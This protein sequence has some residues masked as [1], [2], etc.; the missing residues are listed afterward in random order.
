MKGV[1][2]V[3]GH[4]SMPEETLLIEPLEIKVQ[5]VEVLPTVGMVRVKRDLVNREPLTKGCDLSAR[6]LR[7][8]VIE[9]TNN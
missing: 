6:W 5:N 4:I 7:I 1:L 8:G 3:V 9:I 2:P